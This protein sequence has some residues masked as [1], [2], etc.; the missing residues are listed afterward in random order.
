MV[1]GF[2]IYPTY[3]IEDGKAIVKLYG[4][5]EDGR[6]FVT[7]NEYEPYFFIRAQ[8]YKKAKLVNTQE[9]TIFKESNMRTP[10]GNATMMV[11]TKIPAHVGEFRR[12]LAQEGI[13]SYEA[14]I[15]FSYRF[16]MDKSIQG[17][18]E[19]TGT[20]LKSSNVDVRFIEP[21]LS[22]CDNVS[23]DLNILSFDIETVNE[24]VVS[25]SLYN[26]SIS[27][28]HIISSKNIENNEIICY[29]NERALLEAFNRRIKSI[30]P[31]ILT[32]WNIIDFDF[33]FLRKRFK[34][35]AIP[36]SFGRTDGEAKLILQS[37][38]FRTS[39]IKIPGRVA[40]DGL[41]LVRQSF[42]KLDDYKLE[43]ASQ[44]ILGEG[45]YELKG[46]NKLEAISTL[47]K[48]SPEQ[49]AK[50]NLQDSRLVFEI[51]KEKKLIQL[52]QNRSIITGMPLDRVSASIASLDS[53]YL[54]KS[55]LNNIVCPS[56]QESPRTER[57]TG[58][59]VRDPKPGIY[60]NVLV[61]D[62]K[63]LYPSII[64]T[65]NID[66]FTYDKDG[67]IVAPNDARFN[68][69]KGILP[70][71]IEELWKKRD[72]AKK[73]NNIFASQAIKLTMNSFFGVLA[74][75]TCR[76]YSL[77]VANAITSF[78]RH[79]VKKT[80]DIL[81]KKGYD[82]LYGD[83]DSIFILSKAN[84]YQE[85][86]KLGLEIE[87]F[88]N[89]FYD[90]FLK[91]KYHIESCID[92]EFE[93]IYARFFLPKLRHNAGGAKKR[94]AGLIQFGE[95]DYKMDF[96]GLE[97]VRRDWT[98]MAK[99]FQ[100][101]LLQKVFDKQPV[102]LFIRSFVSDLKEGKMDKDLIYRKGLR[103][104]VD[105][106]TKT[107]PPHV[108]AAMKLKEINSYVISYYMT[109]DGPEPVENTTHALDYNHYIERQIRPIAESVL[110][111]FQKEFD[112]VMSKTSQTSLS[113]F[114]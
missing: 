6:S 5:L 54:R 113:M 67:E 105:N 43:T 24:K 112:D 15:R 32:G 69:N 14:D 80:A 2:I 26:N 23:I 90:N 1:C 76:F 103:K 72:I 51:L 84:N 38:Y 25:F 31:D 16:M 8:D 29:E 36:F 27:E 3:E 19:I 35:Y 83:T 89:S 56:R 17:L 9:D 30:D 75:P 10:D 114:G 21:E 91:E 98:E 11:I 68:R 95:N 92:L 102:D 52:T 71:I 7:E 40:L 46:P 49:L 66:P 88:V 64:R 78:G 60:D 12:Q 87:N 106:Y 70:E 82:V 18:I 13:K 96:V 28:V 101:Q 79:I 97:I 94:Y 33:V 50:Y 44:E 99:N 100:K 20:E 34:K 58:G 73:E 108:K 63:S 42:I 57:I 55:R 37:S 53:L 107:T 39:E 104:S 74:N 109:T 65:F 47:W 62:F 81:S 86:K 4:R 48:E 45:K 110:S 61:F 22:S 111:F 77:D 59:Y 85:A 41:N 93:K